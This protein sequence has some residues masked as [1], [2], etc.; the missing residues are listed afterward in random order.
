MKTESRLGRG[1]QEQKEGNK[2]V[3][4][5]RDAFSKSK[6]SLESLVVRFWWC[7]GAGTGEGT[8]QQ[9]PSSQG[10]FLSPTIMKVKLPVSQSAFSL[11]LAVRLES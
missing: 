7:N 6:F 1:G 4:S 11:S 10:F 8:L 2:L 5:S 9:H 3:P